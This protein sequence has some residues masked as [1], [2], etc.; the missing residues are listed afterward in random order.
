MQCCDVEPMAGE[1]F[2][3]IGDID[4]AVAKN[5]GVLDFFAIDFD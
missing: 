5:D 3:Q 2:V 1:G 4:F